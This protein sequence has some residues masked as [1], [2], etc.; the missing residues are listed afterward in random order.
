MS[1]TS[2]TSA[3]ALE[4]KS[5]KKKEKQDFDNQKAKNAQNGHYLSMYHQLK[6]KFTEYVNKTL[7]LNIWTTTMEFCKERYSILYNH[8]I[9]I[10]VST[11]PRGHRFDNEKLRQFFIL[12]SFYGH[13]L[14][15]I[16]KSTLVFP[17]WKTIMSWKKDMLSQ[18]Q[19]S[20]DGSIQSIKNLVDTFYDKD[21][22]DKR[23]VVAI[24]AVSISPNITID[25]SGK[26]TGLIDIKSI[27]KEEAEIII[28]SP[29]K[30]VEFIHSNIENV[31]K[32]YFVCYSCPLNKNSISIPFCIIPRSNGNACK[33]VLEIFDH[34]LE[35]LSKSGINVVG[36]AYDGDTAWLTRVVLISKILCKYAMNQPNLALENIAQLSFAE[37][38]GRF[39]YEDMLHLIKCD[40]YRKSSG[41][42]LC[43]ALYN[44]EA[45]ISQKEF[46]D[47]G[48]PPWIM[49]NKRY[50]KMDDFL[51]IKLFTYYNIKH[52][53]DMHRYDLAFSLIP[54]T[55]LVE[56]VL[57]EFYTREQRL[58]L[59]SIG[60][61]LILIYY[62]EL[63]E[64]TNNP[65][66]EQS[67]SKSNGHGK[68]VTLFEKKHCVKYLSLCA[69][70]SYQ[71]ST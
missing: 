68:C 27:K 5:K 48:I 34:V 1:F 21:F 51:P 49:N 63:N 50:S 53:R 25:N 30:F 65:H 20:L 12:L 58:H 47:N 41:A 18:Y 10:R 23:A 37:N 45:T 3:K 66:N 9:N 26:V 35:N 54:S 24:D 14:I 46:V 43:P 69:A 28:N 7:F 60:F 2:E 15:E 32:Y 19:I 55:L 36:E 56:A 29:D 31:I 11:N 6:E 67:T 62:I 40:R 70:L 33:T 22:T 44:N 64:Y 59:L 52:F 57:N 4:A 61:S 38:F 13:S 8:I 42:C 17:C 16:L 71:I 39:I